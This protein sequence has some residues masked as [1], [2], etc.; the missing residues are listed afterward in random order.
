MAI[1]R[2][3]LVADLNADDQPLVRREQSNSILLFANS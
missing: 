1:V 3:L 2:P